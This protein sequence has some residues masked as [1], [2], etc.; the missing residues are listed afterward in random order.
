MPCPAA[1]VTARPTKARLSP[2][3]LH[4]RRVHLRQPSSEFS[5]GAE[6]VLPAQLVFA[7]SVIAGRRGRSRT[8]V[9]GLNVRRR[10]R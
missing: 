5:V 6:V 9:R 2:A 7:P 8:G 3:C 4:P 10:W 1:Q